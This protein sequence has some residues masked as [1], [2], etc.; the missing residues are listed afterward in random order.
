VLRRSAAGWSRIKYETRK[1]TI[2]LA[3]CLASLASLAQA[4]TRPAAN[5]PTSVVA[6]ATAAVSSGGYVGA[7][8]CR[9]CHKPEF[10]EFNKTVHAKIKP[11]KEGLVTGCEVCHGPGKAHADAEQAAHGDDAK[12]ATANKLI[13]AFKGSPRESWERCGQCHDSS[14]E[15]SKFQQSTHARHGVACSDCH[16]THLVEA[17][18]NPN[19]STL[20]GAQA[21]FFSV[22]QLGAET[23]W[24]NNSLLKESQPKLCSGCHANIVAQFALP[25]HHPV[26]EG[27]MKCTDCHSPHGTGNRAMLRETNWETCVRCHVEKRGPWVFEHASVAVEGCVACHTPHGSINKLLLVRREERFLCLSCHVET[28]AVNVPH[29]RMSFQTSGACTRCHTMIHGSNFDVDF[30]H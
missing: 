7:E 16:A 19:H 10:E 15:Q 30:L 9:S 25:N 26:P 6:N 24:L 17:A 29:G 11:A 28:T 14:H 23:R 4:Q 21:A 27:A 5:E 2:G 12:T 20:D 3:W 18:R 13:F 1:W 22:P 8:N